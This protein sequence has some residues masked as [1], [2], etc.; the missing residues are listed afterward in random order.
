MQNRSPNSRAACSPNC[1]SEDSEPVCSMLF[2][3]PFVVVEHHVVLV[4]EVVLQVVEPEG[5]LAVVPKPPMTEA[6]VVKQ[7][8]FLYVSPLYSRRMAIPEVEY[9]PHCRASCSPRR[10]FFTSAT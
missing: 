7:P 1:I 6:L 4:V 2:A 10:I 9:T 3:K 8:L 5:G